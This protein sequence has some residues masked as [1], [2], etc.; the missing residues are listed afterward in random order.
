[1]PQEKTSG[2]HLTRRQFVGTAAATAGMAATG[3]IAWSAV[4]QDIQSL[5]DL[6]WDSHPVACNVCGGFCGLLLMQKKGEKPSSDTVRI[7]PN[8]DHPQ[9]GYCA[10]GAQA[11]YPWNHP[12]RL[13]RPLKLVGEKGSGQ[14]KEITWDQ[15]LNEIAAKVRKICDKDGERAVSLTSHNF[16]GYQKWFSA[17]LG[18]PNQ[19]SHSGSCNSSSI[20][21]RRMVFGKGFDG[22]GK[23]EPDYE[24]C[25]MLVCIG[26]SLNCAIGIQNVVSKAR[27]K[28]LKVVYIDPRMPQA[29]LSGAQW[30]PIKPGTDS[31]LVLWI[32]NYGLINGLADLDWLAKHSNAAYLVNAE[33]KKPITQ[34]TVQ[35]KGSPHL[36]AVVDAATGKLKFQGQ[37]TKDGKFVGF[38][39]DNAPLAI[40]YTGDVKLSDGS[41]VT[42]KSSFAVLK[43]TASKYPCSRVS[44]ITGI[45]EDD[46]ITLA[47]DFFRLKGTIDDG[48]YSAKNGNDSSAYAL[49]CIANLLHGEFDQRGGFIVTQGG[50]FGGVKAGNSGDKGSGPHGEKWKLAD[51]KRLDTRFYPEGSGTI[52][53]IYDAILKGDPY[54]VR[55]IFITGSTMFH[56]EAHTPSLEKAL[57]A[58][59]LVVVQDIFPHEVVDYADYVLPSTY[60]LETKD[61]TGV[62][63]ARD[64]YVQ[65]NDG[66]LQPPEGNESRDEIWQF[67]EILRRAYP[68]RAA[69][70]LGYDKEIKTR[71][72]FQKWYG[73]MVDKAWKKF[74]AGKNSAKER[75][76]DRI[77]REV[78]EHGYS[79][80]ATKKYGVI[81]YKKPFGTPTGKAEIVSFYVAEKYD[82]SLLSPVHDYAPPKA[83]KQPKPNSDEFYLVSGKDASGS[84]GTTVFTKPAQYLGD[85]TLWMNP[86]DAERLGVR[87]GAEVELTSLDSKEKGR[88]NVRITNRV[89]Q[90]CLFSHAFQGDVRTKKLADANGYEW[91]REGLNTNRL[92]PGYKEPLVG[93]STNNCTVKV[94]IV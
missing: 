20:M 65:I 48:W 15:A 51:G 73:D 85:R 81:P 57:K 54:P 9:R 34:T 50:G 61:Y 10:R 36:Y 93:S 28:G 90:G 40:D 17:A 35:A 87:N 94:A 64:G 88:V 74:I 60:F 12:L 80:S 16:S 71:A 45:P 6:G 59:E 7:F 62:K 5:K 21:G 38:I 41:V 66:V 23:V 4:K 83:M 46:L 44:K 56:R 69:E 70:R 11:F 31:A 22:A 84:S 49:F 26:R 47:D 55:A 52:S 37:D 29:A 27:Q 24:H 78:A 43:E 67:C 76:G 89:M 30:I 42:V 14:F 53:A 3:T 19:I 18:T 8:P 63:W 79:L 72:E 32:I 86:V 13:K 91:I 2:L 77:G 68:E 25:R 82:G 92:C 1:M 33:T 39:E 58:L 75:D